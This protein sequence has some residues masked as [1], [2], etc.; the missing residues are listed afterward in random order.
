MKSVADPSTGWGGPGV[1]WE[2][3][4]QGNKILKKHPKM[5]IKTKGG[6]FHPFR[7]EGFPAV[8]TGNLCHELPPAQKISLHEEGIIFAFS[9][10]T[11]HLQH[12][13]V[14]Y[15]HQRHSLAQKQEKQL[16]KCL[17]SVLP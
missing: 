4:L 6:F 14:I 13:A 7:A 17:V 5:E 1:F 2:G 8:I 12:S 11:Y 10:S 15:H 16:Q 9:P 3:G